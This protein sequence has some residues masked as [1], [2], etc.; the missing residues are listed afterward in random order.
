[1]ENMVVVDVVS[2]PNTMKWTALSKGENE[3]KTPI[4]ILNTT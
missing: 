2:K 1:M 4:Y 3:F